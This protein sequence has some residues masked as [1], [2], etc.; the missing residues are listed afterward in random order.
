MVL[1]GRGSVRPQVEPERES[2]LTLRVR[3]AWLARVILNLRFKPN[4][5]FISG[6]KPGEPSCAR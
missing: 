4:F 5:N 1:K 2:R 6:A 3:Q